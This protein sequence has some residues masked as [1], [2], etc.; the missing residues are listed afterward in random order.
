MQ[1]E[2]FKRK[3]TNKRT[4]KTRHNRKTARAIKRTS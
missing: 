2:K 3:P 4:D 1:F